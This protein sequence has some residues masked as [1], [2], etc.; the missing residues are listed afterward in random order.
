[1]EC[2][3]REMQTAQPT[4]RAEKGYLGPETVLVGLVWVV[5]VVGILGLEGVSRPRDS[6]RGVLLD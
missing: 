1:M 4:M 6:V 5:R 2:L 3:G